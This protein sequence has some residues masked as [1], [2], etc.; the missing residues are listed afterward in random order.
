MKVKTIFL[1]DI[2]WIYIK[3]I[4]F[5]GFSSWML[6]FCSPL[7]L[8]LWRCFLSFLATPTSPPWHSA[9]LANWAF[10]EPRASLIDARQHHPHIHMWLEPCVP[11]HVP[12]GWWLSP[13]EVWGYLVGWHCCS[14][15]GVAKPFSSFNPFS[16]SSIGAPML[17]QLLAVTIH[18][19][20]Y[21]PWQSFSADSH[22]RLLSANTWYPQ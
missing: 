16:N 14:F 3:Y 20:I 21:K 8:L 5:P 17:I 9:T 22:K 2:L 10:T 18:L 6:L 11:V 4:A 1:V 15:Y 19:C 13:W 7:S 12:F